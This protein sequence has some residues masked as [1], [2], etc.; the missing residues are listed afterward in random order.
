MI[1]EE[2]TTTQDPTT[3]IKDQPKAEEIKD[4]EDQ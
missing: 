2:E 4:Q 1:G 3:I